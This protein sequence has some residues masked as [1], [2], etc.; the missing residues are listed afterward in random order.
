VSAIRRILSP[1]KIPAGRHTYRGKGL[2]TGLAL[3]LRVE[4]DGEGILV[5]NADRVLFLNETAT[6]YVY[7]FMHGLSSGEVMKKIR[8]AYR[9]NAETAK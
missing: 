7:F 4:S 2:L 6:A 5:I 9:V 1:P 3:Q 8:R